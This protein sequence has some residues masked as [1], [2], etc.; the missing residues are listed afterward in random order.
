MPWISQFLLGRPGLEKVFDVNPEALQIQ[1]SGVIVRQRNLAGDLSKAVLKTSAPIIRLNSSYLTL[2]QRNQFSSLVGISDQLLS[3]KTRDDWEVVDELVTL[4]TPTTL[5]ISNSSATRLSKVLTSLGYDSVITIETPFKLGI[6][7][8]S[9]WGEPPMDLG[10]GGFGSGGEPFDP[11]AVT[12]DDAT[13]I[14]TF[15][16]PI[17]DPSQQVLVSYLY[18]GWLVDVDAFNHN[19]QG[20]WLDR[21]TYDFQLVGA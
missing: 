6:S 7:A 17:T 21:F 19:A 2:A 12:Y 18:K 10:E 4:L 15:T 3:F 16:N 1:E 5:K 8:G 9:L 20:G 11:G 13:R 14:V